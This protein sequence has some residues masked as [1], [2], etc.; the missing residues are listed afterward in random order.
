LLETYGAGQVKPGSRIVTAALV[1][2]SGTYTYTSPNRII[3]IAKETALVAN[4]TTTPV[5]FG[6]SASGTVRLRATVTEVAD[7]TPGDRRNAT[8]T[9]IDRATSLTIATVNCDVNGVAT[10]DWAVN[11]G[12]AASKSYT[13]GF[14]VSNYYNRSSTADNA[15]IVVNKN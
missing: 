12:A 4:A 2:P 6:G 1:D 14:I 8:V 9:F 15:T 3:N 13:I 10:F 11:L 7:G 5:S